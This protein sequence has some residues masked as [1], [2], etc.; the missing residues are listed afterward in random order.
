MADQIPT[1]DEIAQALRGFDATRKSASLEDDESISNQLKAFDQ[2]RQTGGTIGPS[3]FSPRLMQMRESL[4]PVLGPTVDQKRTMLPGQVPKGAIPETLEFASIPGR[5]FSGKMPTAQGLQDL[6]SAVTDP[7][8]FVEPY[9]ELPRAGTTAKVTSGI[10]K[11]NAN[12]LGYIAVLGPVMGSVSQASP[13]MGRLLEA[14]VGA[15]IALH[16]P[17]MYDAI[18]SAAKA[19]DEE[20]VAEGITGMGLGMWF[21]Q[22][23]IRR[24]ASPGIAKESPFLNDML[25]RKIRT[26]FTPDQMR[27]MSSRVDKGTAS[28]A[29][30][31]MVSFL[32][33]LEVRN[34][35][36]FGE[37]G[38]SNPDA[39]L[40]MLE[41]APKLNM[42]RLN[43]YLGV[44]G[45]QV[46][47]RRG[48]VGQTKTASDGSEQ[49]QTE[50]AM[51]G[52]PVRARNTQTQQGRNE[53]QDP[54]GQVKAQEQVQSQNRSEVIPSQSQGLLTTGEPVPSNEPVGTVQPSP[55][56]EPVVNES[57]STETPVQ[58][59]RPS[60]E[61]EG[62]S[63]N[64]VT[65]RFDGYQ[66]L[67]AL[68][69]PASPQF[70]VT[71]ESPGDLTQNGSYLG[72]G[73]DKKG[74]KPVTPVPTLEQWQAS[75]STP[76]ASLTG[77]PS[78][79][80]NPV[81]LSTA[82]GPT[83]IYELFRNSGMAENT[84]R[85]ATE[86]LNQPVMQRPEFS[87]LQ[88]ALKNKLE[89][90][91]QSARGVVDEFNNLVELSRSDANPETIVHESFHLL[92]NMLDPKD[93]ALVERWRAEMIR[94]RYGPDAPVSLLSGR[95]TSQEAAELGI[96][97]ADYP[98]INTSEF[99][100]EI[101]SNQFTSESNAR[102]NSPEG[103]SLIQKIKEWL[104]SLLE[105]IK[106]ITGFSPSRE[107]FVRDI[108][109]GKRVT[110]PESGIK[111]E[112][113]ASFSED[114]KSAQNAERLVQNQKQQTTEGRQQ[115][116]QVGDIVMALDKFGANTIQTASQNILRYGEY[117]GIQAVGERMLGSGSPKDYRALKAQGLD[118]YQQRWVA[119]LAATQQHLF[120]RVLDNA[121]QERDAYLPKLTSPGFLKTLTREAA[122]KSRLDAAEVNL[123]VVNAMFD[124]AIRKANK[125]LRFENRSEREID[126][127]KGQIQELED[128]KSSSSAMVQLL[129]D[130]VT[131]LSSTPEGVQ[132][133]T[134]PNFSSRTDIQK[135]YKD[136]KT[137]ASMP[138]HSPS[139]IKWAAY[140]IQKSKA[141]RE[142]LVAAHLSGQAPIRNAMNR[143]EQLLTAGL[144]S[145]P[146]KTIKGLRRE[147]M[148]MASEKEKAKFAWQV[149]NKKVVER[150]NEFNV[151]NDAAEVATKIINDPDYSGLV[152][153]VRQDAGWIGD[154]KPFE[155]FQNKTVLLPDGKEVDVSPGYFVG[156][157]T[158]FGQN[159]AGME[160]A[161][162]DLKNW[163]N[164]TANQNDPNYEVHARDVETLEN[165]FTG[166]ALM[167]PNDPVKAFNTTFGILQNSADLIGGRIAV[168][169]RKSI[170]KY[171]SMHQL[172]TEW[173]QRWSNNLTASRVAAMKSHDLKW[174][175]FSDQTLVEANK[176][177]WQMVGNPLAYSHNSQ[178]GGYKV[179]DQLPTGWKVTKADMD[180]LRMMVAASDDAFFKVQKN[181][182]ASDQSYVVDSLGGFEFYRQPIKGAEL[183]TPRKFELDF[184]SLGESVSELNDTYARAVKDGNQSAA[185][186]ALDRIVNVLDQNWK[187]I[188]PSLVS[189][190][191]PDFAV[192]TPFDGP[193]G[194]FEVL[195]P[196][197]FRIPS[198]TEFFDQVSSLTGYSV[199]E[200]KEIIALEWARSISGWHREAKTDSDVAIARAQEQAN[201]FTRSR[202]KALAPYVFYEN[203]FKTST[204]MLRFGSGMQSRA[205]DEVASA[206]VSAKADIQRQIDQFNQDVLQLRAAGI[207]SPG[208]A[209][210]TAQSLERANGQN[211]DSYERLQ[212]RLAEAERVS[213]TLKN[214]EYEDPDTIAGRYI[215]LVTG[216]LIGVSTTLR[217]VTDG[218]RYLG[219]VSNR[220]MASNLKAYP[221]AFFYGMV[222]A[223]IPMMLSG[224]RSVVQGGAK[225]GLGTMTATYRYIMNPDRSVR[226]SVIEAMEPFMKE[227]GEDMFNRIKA[228]RQMVQD[229]IVDAPTPVAAEMNA[230]LMGSLLTRGQILDTELTTAEKIA[231]APAS[232]AELLFL[233]P[234][235]K[236]NPKFGDYS[237]NSAVDMMMMSSVG[238]LR[239]HEQRWRVISGMVRNGTR[240]W[241]PANPDNPV[242]RMSHQEI[243]PRSMAGLRFVE[244][245]SDLM[246]ARE[247]FSK[248]G[249]DYDR[250]AFDFIS[251]V[252]SGQK[253]QPFSPEQRN[254]LRS[255]A[256]NLA[257]RSTEANAP[258]FAKSRSRFSRFLSPFWSWGT[259]M[260]SNFMNLMAVPA[261]K[262]GRTFKN[263]SELRRARVAQWVTMV[264]T[265]LF[266]LL[267]LG[268]LTGLVSNEEL[269]AVKKLVYNQVTAYRQ[270]WER[271]GGES[272][273]IGFAVEGMNNIPIIG[274]L[275]SMA[276]NDIPTRATMDPNFVMLDKIKQ[277][278]KYVGGVLQTGD[279]RYKLP[280]FVIGMI[281]DARIV[282]SRMDGFEGRNE[283]NNTA[284]VLRRYGPGESMK[285]MRSD[286]G[287]VANDLTPYADRMANAAM[288]GDDGELEKIY[289]EAVEVARSLGRD[290]PERVV[291]EM[292]RSRNPYDRVFKS[293]LTDAQRQKILE[294]ASPE[295]RAMVEQAEQK[296]SRASE[297]INSS[298]SFTSEQAGNNRLNRSSG[299]RVGG[300]YQALGSAGSNAGSGASFLGSPSR[301]RSTRL[302]SRRGRRRSSGLRSRRTRVR[303]GR[304]R[305]RNARRR[306]NFSLRA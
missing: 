131:V 272:K 254:S 173:M 256:I 281:P 219:Q 264:M 218:P 35:E 239:Y 110:T 63:G 224:I 274:G 200:S 257:N 91:G 90:G 8:G 287:S 12:A 189:D 69:R 48:E 199:Q 94:Q 51:I 66:D 297:R 45:R 53:T 72:E 13:L 113:R 213:Q 79:A 160:T 181:L 294:S 153:E 277:A 40:D 106:R 115:V 229:G 211:F 150:L 16:M 88:V 258:Q 279:I 221:V 119:R 15:D 21:G 220:L 301:T 74:Y 247:F 26:Q 273:A 137:S 31:E 2:Q 96:P 306:G 62:P 263:I 77:E 50:P 6:Y 193:G 251:Q 304:S 123:R 42:P 228:I 214:R 190:R 177:W 57:L 283:L 157:K 195:A 30:K 55:T 32:R 52:E 97:I 176:V 236:V 155:V 122:A 49:A 148:G 125:A 215:G 128:A 99:L 59:Q 41:I 25:T 234:S 86:F 151:L 260:L 253:P 210:R 178:V 282:V 225:L 174:A 82:T 162:R 121:I 147:G 67:S 39:P 80:G 130:M 159:R 183:M 230:R 244:D 168:G 83:E 78:V 222:R 156:N 171:E 114:A 268:A 295:E 182:P 167:Q 127:I 116:G 179:G 75:K 19:G 206:F 303:T 109:S 117:V 92:H 36:R 103:R 34:V 136:I 194:A 249:L 192:A 118:P 33:D 60:V 296:F 149:L 208:K 139:L 232:V 70:T 259:R 231:L 302:G 172:S 300:S 143:Y 216:A 305:I 138:L 265:V 269:R 191:N 226:S 46:L 276:I 112:K 146:V 126:A 203:G 101:A 164:N 154:Q 142:N 47:L 89:L 235:Q 28:P 197:A 17:E 298:A 64:R 95:M 10:L 58:V 248:A 38:R 198:A 73:L 27:D 196:D 98:L 65:M 275:M 292:F 84:V 111:Y 188:G 3:S 1:D 56:A 135:V 255:S 144:Q 105:T 212:K 43:K 180:A 132:L 299:S 18:E 129:E 243:F 217:N 290:N 152:Q 285:P 61:F 270:P 158:L 85:V 184:I 227:I 293:K 54:Q 14:G 284:N 241:D 245:D 134:D 202:N 4:A 186:A 81:T 93:Q 29:E 250:L 291:R 161:I 267:I 23:A 175:S 124:T 165:Y 163:L 233:W 68:G 271:E 252:S 170:R 102:A 289:G 266:P 107:Q 280:E 261:Q 237:L 104:R 7:E 5:V 201:S 204:S 278:V 288:A 22:R 20:A 238:P 242:N 24:A 207:K 141:L 108:L 120:R 246:Y 44:E 37:S 185:N 11:G 169:L 71:G 205:L 240:A 145:D 140:L 76:Q 100:A 166:Q 262:A 209:A 187:I 87:G 286:S 223:Q 133:L 9:S